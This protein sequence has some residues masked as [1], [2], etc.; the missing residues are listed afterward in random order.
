MAGMHDGSVMAGIRYG[1]VMTGIRH[2]SG[3]LAPGAIV[4]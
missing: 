4:T 3:Q 1:S 2:G